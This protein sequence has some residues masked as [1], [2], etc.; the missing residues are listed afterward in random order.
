MDFLIELLLELFFD[1]VVGSGMDILADPQAGKG[2]PR[3]LRI[4]LGL[5]ALVF[6]CGVFI[7]LFYF[8]I[9][10]ICEGETGLGIFLLA[11]GIV[12]TAAFVLKT[13]KA[14]RKRR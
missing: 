7:F 5:I 1:L 6:L 2:L 10:S 3:G 12:L 11:V 4:F 13:I 8:G 9:R 14:I